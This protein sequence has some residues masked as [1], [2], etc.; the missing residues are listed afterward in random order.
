MFRP[1]YAP[2]LIAGV[3]VAF[4][5]L[6]FLAARLVTQFLEPASALVFPTVW[7]I[8]TLVAALLV[9]QLPRLLA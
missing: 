8:V 9:R 4:L 7:G 1:L 5:T 3:L 2:A 6:T